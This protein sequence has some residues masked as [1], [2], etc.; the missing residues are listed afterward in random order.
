MGFIGAS[1]LFLEHC[2]CRRKYRNG[3]DRSGIQ[4][5]AHWLLTL[6]KNFYHWVPLECMVTLPSFILQFVFWW[7]ANQSYNLKKWET[8]VLSSDA[9][10]NS[11]K[12]HE[13]AFCGSMGRPSMSCYR[14]E[15]PLHPQRFHFPGVKRTSLN[16]ER[17]WSVVM[18][19]PSFLLGYI[20]NVWFCS[21]AGWKGFLKKKR[22][23]IL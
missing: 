23:C 17:H 15:K 16:L 3:R 8:S 22:T 14:M 5:T 7:T 9:L 11:V 20:C 6:I 18:F 1:V 19:M 12:T 4:E 13:D 2:K 21:Q 10:K